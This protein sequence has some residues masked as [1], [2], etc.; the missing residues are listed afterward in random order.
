[1]NFYNWHAL[2]RALLVLWQVENILQLLFT[3]CPFPDNLSRT[4]MD[5]SR[6][7]FSFAHGRV[8]IFCS[9]YACLPWSGQQDSV[10]EDRWPDCHL[11]HLLSLWSRASLQFSVGFSSLRSRSGLPCLPLY[12]WKVL[13]K[14]W[15]GQGYINGKGNHHHEYLQ[16]WS[17]V[18]IYSFS[19][20]RIMAE[21]LHAPALFSGLRMSSA[22]AMGSSC[23]QGAC[24]W[25]GQQTQVNQ[26][27]KWFPSGSV[28][29]KRRVR[30]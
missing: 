20:Q 11:T 29:G 1:M 19:T 24:I 14:W 12:G 7:W 28:P 5:I 18:L 22:Q 15:N 8:H 3:S 16:C 6:P 23:P 27:M 26:C 4:C 9:H 25:T 17:H 30:M 2:I 10:I 21:Y 13:T